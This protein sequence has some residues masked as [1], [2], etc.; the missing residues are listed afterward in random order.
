MIKLRKLDEPQV[1]EDHSEAWTTELLKSI[2]D[3]AD[4]PSRLLRDRY[5][6][7]KVK[8]R[9]RLECFGKCMYCESKIAHITHE[10][11]EHIKPKAKDKY[12][13]LTFR[14]QNLGL[15]CPKCNINKGSFYDESI[16]FVNPYVEKPS[17]FFVAVGHFIYHKP[18]NTRAEIT[19]KR[20]QLNRVGLI[21]QRKERIDAVRV[22]ADKYASENNPELKKIL[23]SEVKQE[24]K[25]DKPY[26]ACTNSVISAL[27]NE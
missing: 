23:L 12:P 9:L 4:I 19:E 15:A 20:I 22:L 14:W 27:L 10:H 8:E 11:V 17:D 24:L 25:E 3:G 1:L 21:E 16:P 26:S 5:G 6:H 13:E 18:G 2:N 7:N